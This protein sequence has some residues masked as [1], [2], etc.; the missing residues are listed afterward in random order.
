MNSEPKA[1]AMMSK[2]PNGTPVIKRL[3]HF[4][5]PVTESGCWIWLGAANADG[6]GSIDIGDKSMRAHRASWE[7][8]RGP[9]PEGMSVLHRCDVPSCINPDHL[10]L[11]T[12]LENIAD[13]TRKGRGKHQ[14]YS[15]EA[16]PCCKL[17][18]ATVDY[19]RNSPLKQRELARI[20][21]TSQSH[22]SNIQ[23]GKRWGMT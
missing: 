23:R 3:D 16:H 10:F 5:M 21:G 22:V 19:I 12:Q 8:H 2:L 15:G 11:G 1:K 7:A 17:T 4:S 18:A 9:V 14:V 6:Y 13:R 20:F